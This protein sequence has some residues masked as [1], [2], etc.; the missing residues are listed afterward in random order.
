MIVGLG[1]IHIWKQLRLSSKRMRRLATPWLFETVSFE[2][3]RPSY[4]ALYDIASCLGLSLCVKRLI[5]TRSQGL[6]RF[7]EYEHWKKSVYLPGTPSDARLN[8]P[9]IFEGD[10]DASVRQIPGDKALISY[11]EWTA[12]SGAQREA[13]YD[14]Y[15]TDRQGA[16]EQLQK[17]ICS[18]QFLCSGTR[19]S[20]LIHL[21]RTPQPT[22][23]RAPLTQL[24]QVLAKLCNLAHFEHEPGFLRS[25]SWSVRWRQLRF[26]PWSLMD[27]TD[28]CEDEHVEALQLSIV[29]RTLGCIKY[30]HP[31]PR[32]LSMYVGGPAFWGVGRLQHLWLGVGHEIT[33]LHRKLHHTAAEADKHAYKDSLT[34]E[35]IQTYSRQLNMIRHGFSR[36]TQLECSV[37]EDDER[38]GSLAI[39][40]FYLSHFLRVNKDLE[41]IRLAFGRLVDG[42]VVPGD[43]D[44]GYVQDSCTL[45]LRLAQN[46]PWSKLRGIELEIATTRFALVKFLRAHR[47]TLRSLTLTRVT[48]VRLEDD[49]SSWEY[50]LAEIMQSLALV[51]LNLSRLCDFLPRQNG[52]GTS[53]RIL[54]DPEADVWLDKEGQYESY[55][56][57]AME[58]VHSGTPIKSLESDAFELWT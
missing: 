30:C 37:F 46:T 43:N 8:W 32:S 36:I 33:R 56:E 15:E 54:F 6:R 53:Q 13:L 21:D 17:M 31:K 20:N 35:N 58:F 25:D 27:H 44:K 24:P 39:A 3:S 23:I 14:E 4:T 12:L 16:R 42:T 19:T 40:G 47:K 28:A 9:E 57:K 34:P 38:D 52:H 1:D 7:S 10:S 51:T 22:E 45:L 50:T 48:I 11:S 2:L 5:L 29:L 18:L 49:L 55:Y 26:H 41:S